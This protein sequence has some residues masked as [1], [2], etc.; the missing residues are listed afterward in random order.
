[1]WDLNQNISTLT[2][3]GHTND[4]C[5]LQFDEH[6]CVSGSRDSLIKV[7][8]FC[9]KDALNRSLSGVFWLIPF[10]ILSS[11]CGTL[12]LVRVWALSQVIPMVQYHPNTKKREYRDAYW[13]ILFNGVHLFN[14]MLQVCGQYSMMTMKLYLHHGVITLNLSSTW[15]ILF[16]IW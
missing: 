12:K 13:V 9:R 3:L 10:F 15:T 11:R 7:I 5:S 14:V 6:K 8:I 4:V 2:M 16:S 1:M